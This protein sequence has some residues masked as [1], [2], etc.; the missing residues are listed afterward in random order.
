MPTPKLDFRQIQ[1]FRFRRS[2]RGRVETIE[3]LRD[4]DLAFPGGGLT[5]VIG[6]ADA[7]KTSLLR[8]ATR[9]DEPNGGII[10]VDGED[11]RTLDPRGLR[12]RVALVGER[13]RLFGERIEENLTFGPIAAGAGIDEAR[14][15]A[16]DA[17]ERVGLDRSYLDRP[18][19]TLSRSQRARVVLARALT[20]EPEVVLLDEW[21]T[22]LDPDTIDDVFAL[23][24]RLADGGTTIVFAASRLYEAKRFADRIVVLVR[25]EIVADRPAATFALDAVPERARRHLRVVGFGEFG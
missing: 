11:I 12:R 14:T 20:L 9:L 6:P 24:R 16:V 1:K 10:R 7:G 22:P 23:L 4:I 21:T 5:A 25:G 8:L 19:D 18:N 2:P 17:I 15:R 13:H 3:V